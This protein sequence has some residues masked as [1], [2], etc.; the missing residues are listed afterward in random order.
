MSPASYQTAPPRAKTTNLTGD[1]AGVNLPKDPFFTLATP[2]LHGL[3]IIVRDAP[4]SVPSTDVASLLPSG[5][6]R[7]ARRVAP[8]TKATLRRA[9]HEPGVSD[10]GLD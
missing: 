5:R 1:N 9:T 7:D 8:H 2:L 3:K 6:K 4:E 10:A